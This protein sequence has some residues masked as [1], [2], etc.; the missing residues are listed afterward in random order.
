MYS[1]L[2]PSDD[3]AG[4]NISYGGGAID[5]S[6]DGNYLYLSC[7]QDDNGIAKL[8]IPPPGGLARVV[9]PCLG[10]RRADIAKVHP[11]LS[12]WRP[13]LG[14]VLE[15]N[16]RI[17]VTG[18]I[19]YDAN[20]AATASH[21]SGPSLTQLSGPFAGTVKPGLVKSQMIAVPQEWRALVGGPA[22]SSAGYSSIVSRSSYGAAATV[23][24]PADVTHDQ[25]LQPE[26]H[27]E[28]ERADGV[29]L[30]PRRQAV[31]H[32]RTGGREARAEAALGHQAIR[33]RRHAGF[34]SG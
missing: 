12:A 19:I 14:G 28:S 4:T 18:F 10:P 27:A 6:E 2:V 24:D 31:R 33:H 5:V 29:S 22:M 7:Q 21:W 16:G 9:A 8:E 1:F 20:G 34:G 17:T 3:G 32:A 15:L 23:F 30:P 11:D 26:R 25:V 13:V